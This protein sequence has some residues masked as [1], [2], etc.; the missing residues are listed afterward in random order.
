MTRNI[1]FIALLMLLNLAPQDKA[2][3]QNDS[4]ADGH[5]EWVKAYTGSD[6]SSGT[7][8]NHVVGTVT[9]SRGNLYV[10]G[11]C[12]PGASINGVSL[13]HQHHPWLRDRHT[14]IAKLTPEGELVW[15]RTISS[16]GYGG[17]IAIRM[18]GDTSIACMGAFR[19][20]GPVYWLDTFYTDISNQLMPTD[21]MDQPTA[22]AFLTFNL[23]GNLLEQHF[24][25]FSPIDSLGK[26]ITTDRETGNPDDSATYT[27]G[28]FAFMGTTF[29][30]D[31][32]GNIIV[33]RNTQDAVIIDDPA[34]STGYS[35][36]TI[37][38]GKLSGFQIWVD[39]HPRFDIFPENNPK[40]WNVA[41][42]KFSPHFERLLN[43]QYLFEEEVG[44]CAPTY[45]M[46]NYTTI[47]SSG[48]LYVVV[49]KGFFS[50]SSSAKVANLPFVFRISN[51]ADGLVVKCDTNLQPI[52][53]GQLTVVEE[54]TSLIYN[55][56]FFASLKLSEDESLLVISGVAQ[57][58]YDDRHFLF[59]GDTVDIRNKAFFIGVNP[60]NGQLKSYGAVES[61][62][63]YHQIDVPGPRHQICVSRNQVY[64][65]VSYTKNLLFGRDSVYNDNNFVN[66]AV[67]MWDTLGNAIGFINMPTNSIAHQPCG[68][69]SLHDSNLYI[70]GYLESSATV[71]LGDTSISYQLNSTAY[72]AKYTDPAFA[73]DYVTPPPLGIDPSVRLIGSLEAYPN[74]TTGEV[75]LKTVG[76][77]VVEVTVVT[78]SGQ[79]LHVP[80]YGDTVRLDNLPAGVYYLIVETKNQFI[81]QQKVIK[82]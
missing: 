71:W 9:D 31:R 25:Q 12:G 27:V 76:D 45:N 16:P 14:F 19:L 42:A 22:T 41:L 24:L 79:V 75:H 10:L 59:N 5:F 13:V 44:E 38:N 11:Q 1:F 63:D 3:G 66:N 23:D 37:E 82:L 73:T 15:H 74:P 26:V 64:L 62:G 18:V 28:S 54:S 68:I 33:F 34:S 70:S 60:E 29:E 81:Y 6:A 61:S 78:S 69:L 65:P 58:I 30:I 7:P 36:Y 80:T 4:A 56:C 51:S 52:F 39:G 77:P 55:S 50:D 21:S 35:L 17:G 49:N 20:V 40:T 57:S 47:D 2:F 8:E 32:R 48:C 67:C 72:I 46:N 53:C 43:Y